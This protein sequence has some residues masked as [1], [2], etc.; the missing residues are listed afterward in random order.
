MFYTQ[1]MENSESGNHLLYNQ[2]RLHDLAQQVGSELGK[3]YKFVEKV[4]ASDGVSFLEGVENFPESV[5]RQS[6][7][8]NLRVQV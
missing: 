3:H 6:T 8:K 4:L 2:N 5:V 7:Q 1:R